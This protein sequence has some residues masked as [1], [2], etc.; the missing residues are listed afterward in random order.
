MELS[1]DT[2]LDDTGK[3]LESLEICGVSLSDCS[4]D[5]CPKAKVIKYYLVRTIAGKEFPF[6]ELIQ[7]LSLE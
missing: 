4:L 2:V 6:S 7:K 1:W 5:N 3:L